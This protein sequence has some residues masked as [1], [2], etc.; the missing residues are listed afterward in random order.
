[1]FTEGTIDLSERVIMRGVIWNANL[2]AQIN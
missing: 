1:M 2:L